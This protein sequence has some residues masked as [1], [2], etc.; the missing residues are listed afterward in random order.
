MDEQRRALYRTLL[1]AFCAFGFI[2]HSHGPATHCSWLQLRFTAPHTLT[3]VPSA[4]C[5]YHHAAYLSHA[6]HQRHPTPQHTPHTC[7]CLDTLIYTHLHSLPHTCF[8]TTMPFVFATR[9]PRVAFCFLR[10]ARHAL[11]HTGD[12]GVWLFGRQRL[13]LLWCVP[14]VVL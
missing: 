10:L 2:L 5:A 12:H 9:A 1:R 6:L 3:P 8:N 4:C 11:A 7:L 14:M 13:T